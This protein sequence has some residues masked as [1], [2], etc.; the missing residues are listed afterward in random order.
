DFLALVQDFVERKGIASGILFFLGALAEG[1]LVT[2]PEIMTV[3]PVPH[4]EHIAGGWEL[5]G[6]GTI[7]P[8]EDRPMVHVHAG[9]GRGTETRTGCLREIAETYLVVEAVVLEF[10]GMLAQRKYDPASGL[11]LPVLGKTF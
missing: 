9:A 1:K 5:F 11:Y 3:P 8:G 10:G 2:G 7:L 6:T 4:Y